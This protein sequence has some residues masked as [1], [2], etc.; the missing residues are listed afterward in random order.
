[1]E[2]LIQVDNSAKTSYLSY[3]R[4]YRTSFESNVILSSTGKEFDELTP[5]EQRNAVANS[6]MFARVEPFHKSK[7][8]EYLQSMNEISA[9]TGDGVNDAPGMLFNLQLLFC[10]PSQI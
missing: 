4:L 9:M 2:W 10:T 5:N 6:R 8:V 1:M 3:F 7:I